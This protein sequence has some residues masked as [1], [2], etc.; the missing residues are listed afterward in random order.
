MG[1]INSIRRG[2]ATA[3]RW[4]GR[5]VRMVFDGAMTIHT[6]IAAGGLITGGV[7]LILAG[8][9]RDY[10]AQGSWKRKLWAWPTIVI[11]AILIAPIFLVGVMAYGIALLIAFIGDLIS[12]CYNWGAN[13]IDAPITASQSN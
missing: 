11:G 7:G 4:V 6:W 3:M 5:G 8:R 1:V 2:V 10:A 12:D 9:L 13:F